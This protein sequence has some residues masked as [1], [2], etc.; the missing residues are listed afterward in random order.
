MVLRFGGIPDEAS[1]NGWNDCIAV[2]KFDFWVALI[3]AQNLSLNRVELYES[4]DTKGT[5]SRA[6]AQ[7]KKRSYDLNPQDRFWQNHKG[8]CVLCPV[9]HCV[10]LNIVID[11]CLQTLLLFLAFCVQKFVFIW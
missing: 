4:A 11:D 5:S 6:H 8:R 1:V 7:K 10:I 3:F 9:L 2:F